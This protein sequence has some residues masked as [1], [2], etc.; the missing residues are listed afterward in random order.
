MPSTTLL[1][2]AARCCRW[3][4]RLDAPAYHKI[5]TGAQHL[6]ENVD[7]VAVN[8]DRKCVLENFV[9]GEGCSFSRVQFYSQ[10]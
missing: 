7:G 10:G 6:L 4:A 3:P 2:K 1:S 9:M 8:D 5:A